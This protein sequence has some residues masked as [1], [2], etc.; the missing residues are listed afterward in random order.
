MVMA[1]RQRKFV[2]HLVRRGDPKS[3]E[4]D[5]CFWAKAGAEE[6]FAASWEMVREVEL[7]RGKKDVGE[8]GLQ[9]SVQTVIL[10]TG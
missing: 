8:S 1:G 6:K 5:R 9:R 2:T 3:V 7:F 4:F 10:K